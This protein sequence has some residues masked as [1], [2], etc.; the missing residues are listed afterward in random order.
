MAASRQEESPDIASSS[1]SG[2]SCEWNGALPFEREYP[3]PV[4]TS[5]PALP[6]KMSFLKLPSRIACPDN[7]T[8]FREASSEVPTREPTDAVESLKVLCWKHDC[9]EHRL[10]SWIGQLLQHQKQIERLIIELPGTKG[11]VQ[12]E[13]SAREK[14][15]TI[16][17]PCCPRHV[18]SSPAQHIM[19]RC[20]PCPLPGK[21]DSL[22]SV[23]T[24]LSHW[25]IQA[26]ISGEQL[27]DQLSRSRDALEFAS[28]ELGC[29]ESLEMAVKNKRVT[30]TPSLQ[31]PPLAADMESPPLPVKTHPQ[32]LAADTM[33]ETPF[34]SKTIENGLGPETIGL[35]Q[36]P[37]SSK[38]SPKMQSERQSVASSA[39]TPLATSSSSRKVLQS[40]SM[41]SSNPIL[42]KPLRPSVPSAKSLDEVMESLSLGNESQRLR[43]EAEELRRQKSRRARFGSCKQIK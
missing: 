6:E 4:Q 32:T 11:Y 41:R 8:A 9:L 28:S 30:W 38:D 15:F 10:E 39:T 19:H 31:P 42:S 26:E 35:L 33:A 27:D 3:T 25:Q 5:L 37:R 17:K 14:Q 22:D 2:Q 29:Y 13:S 1:Q 16:G 7:N 23:S 34:Q 12:M 43:R 20:N 40:K 24:S 36:S 21:S 18:S